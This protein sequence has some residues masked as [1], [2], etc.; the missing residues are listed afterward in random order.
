M[1]QRSFIGLG[2]LLVY[3][4]RQTHS[5]K[6]CSVDEHTCTSG[7]CLTHSSVGDS[8]TG[9]SSGNDEDSL[10]NAT[11]EVSGKSTPSRVVFLLSFV[12]VGWKQPLLYWGTS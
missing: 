1:R 5:Q 11:P 3:T 7:Q 9:C 12:I 4:C 10:R 2:Q 6:L 8:G